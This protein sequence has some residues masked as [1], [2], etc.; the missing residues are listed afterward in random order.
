[1]AAPSTWHATEGGVRREANTPPANPT[2]TSATPT[3]TAETDHSRKRCPFDLG[4]RRGVRR[5]VGDDDQGAISRPIPLEPDVR[6]VR[7]RVDGLGPL[8]ARPGA[9]LVVVR[10][11]LGEAVTVDLGSAAVVSHAAD[12]LRR[13]RAVARAAHRANRVRVGRGDVDRLRVL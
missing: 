3:T 9:L 10:S 8:R 11:I 1:M 12:L 4:H 2:P 6:A 13:V 5:V 7:H